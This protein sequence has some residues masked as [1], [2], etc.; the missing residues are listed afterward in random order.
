MP[1]A[2][3][4]ATGADIIQLIV[5]QMYD[6]LEPLATEI[7]APSLYQ[8]YLHEGDYRRLQGI[9]TRLEADARRALDN[10]IARL[11]RQAQPLFV[12][13]LGKLRQQ[14]FSRP[15]KRYGS[16]DGE[17]H[18]QVQADPDEALEPGQ[19]R[20]VSDLAL[21][22]EEGYGSGSKTHRIHSVTRNLKELTGRPRAAENLIPTLARFSYVDNQGPQVYE[23]KKTEIV[24]G[25]Q[26]VNAMTDIALDTLQDVSREHAYVKYSDHRFFIKDVGD[27][28]TKVNGRKVQASRPNAAAGGPDLDLWVPLRDGDTI[29]LA[30]V[31]TLDF[32]VVG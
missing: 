21:G 14:P 13:L 10:E 31:I 29:E 11:N 30:D 4:K 2:V 22:P 26:A 32:E 5:E 1:D 27:Y 18:I 24:I 12:R 3:A 8:V 23:M 9:L 28:G 25:R 6:Q 20:V 16:A 7:L 19:V 17:W 15:P